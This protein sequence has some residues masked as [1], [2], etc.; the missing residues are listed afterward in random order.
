MNYCNAE[1]DVE[2]EKALK[3]HLHSVRKHIDELADKNYN[4]WA[5]GTLDFVMMFI[6]NESSYVLAMQHDSS[7][8]SD[9]YR[10]RILLLSPANLI[11]ELSYMIN[12]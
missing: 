12:V 5:R 8:W 10:K 1:T 3:E 2:R 4:N 9:A 11:G 6:P 7:L